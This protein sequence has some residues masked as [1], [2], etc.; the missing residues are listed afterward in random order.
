MDSAGL[1][2]YRTGTVTVTQGSTIIVGVGTNWQ[3]AGIKPGDIFK[4]GEDYE[5]AD[6][7]DNTTITLYEAFGGASGA[8]QSYAIVRNFAGTMQAEIAAQVA[9]LVNKYE[10]YIDADLEQIVGP[11][12]PAG[13]TF[14]GE[15]AAGRIYEALD[16]V[17][18]GG[19][20][21][22]AKNNHTSTTINAPD[23]ASS[24]WSGMQIQIGELLQDIADLKSG[25]VDKE[26]GKGLSSNDY[27]S[28][29]KTKLAEL[30][31]YNDTAIKGRVG[32]VETAIETLNGTGE[33]SV[34]KAVEDG[35]AAI[36]ANA[37]DD[38]DTLK[39]IADYIAS[40]K[41]NAA[42]M[43]NAIAANT[44][45]LGGHTVG[46][47]VPAGAV[48]TDTLYDDTGLAGRV[49]AVEIGK[50]TVSRNVTLYVATDGNDAT[51]DGTA[52]KPF[53]TINHA[54]DQLGDVMDNCSILV[55]P[56][57]YTLVQ[58]NGDYGGK[59]SPIHIEGKQGTLTICST[60]GLNAKDIIFRVT[61]NRNRNNQGGVVTVR[62][63]VILALSGF[64][65]HLTG[66]GQRQDGLHAENGGNI[67]F[68]AV[69][70]FG[71]GGSL[72]F[73]LQAATHGRIVKVNAGIKMLISFDVKD[74][75][76]RS[77]TMSNGGFIHIDNVG[78]KTPEEGET[79]Y[80]PQ[81]VYMSWYGGIIVSNDSTIDV[82]PYGAKYFTSN[83]SIYPASV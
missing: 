23:G 1:R 64:V 56:G 16:V 21:Y 69:D 67:N 9:A 7:A 36:V 70:I 41:T 35:I 83:T 43:N 79:V 15:W 55:K 77:L 58:A 27:T 5:I 45:A 51:G 60:N 33:G 2:W 49:T 48:F 81:Y 38:L 46:A 6:V 17:V 72:R 39:E 54:I 20:L 53:A 42:Q 59:D 50:A 71:H 78:L 4:L 28:A 10:S 13:M 12:G 57:T 66:T 24:E 75:N 80:G 47:D 63:F 65:I 8:A 40:D 62:G 68:H 30:N 19:L 76:L 61:D 73:I 31:N 44:T 11:R 37:P 18:Y 3:T 14:K 82:S 22:I 25:K 74:N 52:A 34:I 26:T 29:E 32:A